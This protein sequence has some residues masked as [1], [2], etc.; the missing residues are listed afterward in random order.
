M[1]RSVEIRAVL[2]GV[3]HGRELF[4]NVHFL[5]TA[6]LSLDCFI[7][8]RTRR[9]TILEAGAEQ[10]LCTSD[11]E[12]GRH[13]TSARIAAFDTTTEDTQLA[14][15]AII[16][17]WWAPFHDAKRD[18]QASAISDTPWVRLHFGSSCPRHSQ[19]DKHST[20]TNLVRPVTTHCRHCHTAIATSNEAP[21]IRS[22]A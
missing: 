16:D 6:E 13:P 3:A 11:E 20:Q 9:T 18:T 8:Q 17:Y 15:R 14:L 21:S 7:C 19:A 4:H 22:L 5:E 2:T 1:L 10:A 12:H